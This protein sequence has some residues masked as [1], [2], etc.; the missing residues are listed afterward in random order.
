MSAVLW[1]TPILWPLLA[2]GLVVVASRGGAAR[3]VPGLVASGPAPALLL[4]L[5][6][7]A[8]PPPSLSWLLLGLQLDLDPAARLLLATTSLVWLAAGIAARALVTARWSTASLWLLTLAGN[9]G[10]LLAGDLVSLYT[11]YAV[12]T[13]AAY[14]LVVHDRSPAA[15]RAGRIYLVMAVLGEAL[16]IS[17]LMLA[18]GAAGSIDT[19]TVAAALGDAAT[20]RRDLIV[21]LVTAGFAVKA[22]VVPLHVWLPLA[23]PAA[24]VPASAVL[25]GAMIKAGLVGWL[26][27]L[28]LGAVS[29]PSWS[30]V[31]IGVGLVT[32]FAA[33]AVGVV[34]DRPKVVL[35]YS[36]IS[37]MGLITVLVGVGLVVPTAAPLATAAAATYA[38]HHGVAKGALFLGVGVR[39]AWAGPLGRRVVLAG[40]VLAGGSL[41]GAPL[42]SG[43]VAKAAMKDAVAALAPVWADRVT[44]LLALAAVATTLL[45]ARLLVLLAR[46]TPAE[47]GSATPG[48]ARRAAPS[49]AEAAALL[50]GWGLLLL[51]TLVAT[52]TLPVRWLA[53]LSSPRIYVAGL[54]DATWPVGVGVLLAVITL[55]LRRRFGPGHAM[56]PG[57]PA[58]DLVVLA[59]AAARPVA[60][61]AGRAVGAITRIRDRLGGL[62]GGVEV[63]VRPGQGFARLDVLL[64]RWQVAGVL[65][66]LVAG[67]LL[68]A[69]GAGSLGG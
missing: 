67:A 62:V 52:W 28:P 33:A 64:R 13:F 65:F 57:V 66:V 2:A 20:G 31:L 6:G 1:V 68:L 26:A 36:S 7:P 50:V 40:T 16:L 44:A 9:V 3:L 27:V 61:V 47:E 54:L 34:Q 38:L 29:A 32:A 43:W 10:L 18:A 59:E 4:A 60:R 41:A 25:S 8:G 69:L 23:H 14:G 55:V 37:Q 63:R 51:A 19:A 46:P 53:P 56:V 45:I 11:L 58:G 42:T 48:A 5:L 21:G 22:G 15:R 24:P 35:A 39:A 12:M 17:G 30:A 49:L